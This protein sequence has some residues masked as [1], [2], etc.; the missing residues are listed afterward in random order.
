MTLR[1]VTAVAAILLIAA[2]TLAAALV[3]IV[4]WTADDAGGHAKGYVGDTGDTFAWWCPTE[5]GRSVWKVLTM[6]VSEEDFDRSMDRDVFRQ[7]SR[8]VMS[9]VVL[10]DPED[11]Y[12]KKVAA[13][14]E[15]ATAGCSESVKATAA[16]NF[17]QCAIG[18]ESDSDLYGFHEWWASPVET[19]YLHAGDCEDQ[20]V[21]LCSI[22]GAMGIRSVMLDY[23]GHQAVGVYLGDS[24]E[25][26]F[27][28]ATSSLP[29]RI[30]YG[31]QKYLDQQPEEHHPGGSIGVLGHLSN[32]LAGYRNLIG[33]ALG[34]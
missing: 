6:D 1:I 32:G 30:G 5:S 8:L 10:A 11:P 28:E 34:I 3:I 19:L 18:Y 27:C 13:H 33:A 29:T 22:F 15:E 20:A 24:E 7:K 2:L 4:P 12:V 31:D 21:L 9:P 26:L 17:V 14:I 25:Y 16:L 23:P